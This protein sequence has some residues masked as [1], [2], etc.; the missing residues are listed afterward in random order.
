MSEQLIDTIHQNTKSQII[1]Y[2]CTYIFLLEQTLIEEDNLLI[3]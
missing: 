1:I 3:D 2:L